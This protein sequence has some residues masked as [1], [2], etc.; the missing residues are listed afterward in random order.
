MIAVGSNSYNNI[1]TKDNND[2]L[3]GKEDTLK[4]DELNMDKDDYNPKMFK[5]S[6]Q[7]SIKIGSEMKGSRNRRKFSEPVH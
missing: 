6:L 3:G 2:S 5:Y 4:K 1:D 7:G